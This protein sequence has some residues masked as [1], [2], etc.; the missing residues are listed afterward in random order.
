MRHIDLWVEDPASLPR[1]HAL[2]TVDPI[3]L[4]GLALGGLAGAAFGNSSSSNSATTPTP[5]S[6]PPQAPAAK[7]PA[8][9]TTPSSSSFIGGVP[10]PPPSTGQKNLLGQ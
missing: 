7:A 5:A 4:T 1:H 8:P 6:P 9:K 3:T 10:A 2:C